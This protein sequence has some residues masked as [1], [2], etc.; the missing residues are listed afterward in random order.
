MWAFFQK[1]VFLLRK[2]LNV[3]KSSV[4]FRFYVTLF[5]N[6]YQLSINTTTFIA[7][8]PPGGASVKR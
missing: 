4:R 8:L 3:K 5:E 7:V 2:N 6:M 1:V